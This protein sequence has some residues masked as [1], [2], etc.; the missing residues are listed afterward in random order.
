MNALV[1][2]EMIDLLYAASQAG[3]RVDLII[4]GICC[5]RPGIKG[6][7][8]NIEVISIVGR[9]LE[10][11]RVY[12]FENGG[13]PEVYM[14]S[15]DL[16][17]RNL[18]RRVE[19]LFPIQDPVLRDRVVREGLATLLAD[20]AQARRLLPDGTYERVR[21]RARGRRRDAQAA[22]LRGPRVPQRAATAAAATP[23]S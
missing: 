11:A 16:M 15:A 21:S 22:F 20:N 6:I 9:F 8:D 12:S 19:V 7:S 10:H 13:T 3:V 23:R 1:D 5:L 17:Q 14:G 2:P 4:R 18:D